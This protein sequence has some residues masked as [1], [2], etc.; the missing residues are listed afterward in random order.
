MTLP[1]TPPRVYM[2]AGRNPPLDAFV[3][4]QLTSQKTTTTRTP[5]TLGYGSCPLDTQIPYNYTYI[6]TTLLPPTYTPASPA[7][8]HS[9][10]YSLAH[11]PTLTH[12]LRCHRQLTQPHTFTHSLTHSLTLTPESQANMETHAEITV[13]SLSANNQTLLAPITSFHTRLL[14]LSPRIHLETPVDLFPTRD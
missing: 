11:S 8:S 12:L 6:L 10:T 9:H 13:F 2:A 14:R 5:K 7:N 1:E 3:C 4:N